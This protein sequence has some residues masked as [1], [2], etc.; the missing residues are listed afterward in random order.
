M[1]IQIAVLAWLFLGER[2]SRQGIIG[3]VFAAMGIL[4]V[5]L[6]PVRKK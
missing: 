2:V 5:N 6:K 4:I 1:L 3:L